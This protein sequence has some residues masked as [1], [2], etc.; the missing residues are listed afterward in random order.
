MLNFEENRDIDTQPFHINILY[1]PASLRFTSTSRPVQ[2]HFFY[3]TR[4]NTSKKRN[5]IS[6]FRAIE[7]NFYDKNAI[8]EFEKKSKQEEKGI[9]TYNAQCM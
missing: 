1:L 7:I 3:S 8:F 4:V 5:S 2:F 6:I 9:A